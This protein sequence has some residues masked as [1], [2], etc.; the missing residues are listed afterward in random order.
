MRVS[1]YLSSSASF[2][3]ERKESERK[4]GELA[5]VGKIS[6]RSKDVVFDVMFAVYMDTVSLVAP[7]P[8][9]LT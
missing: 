9:S 1:P 3:R 8:T 7:F 6:L 4:A 5:C 2:E